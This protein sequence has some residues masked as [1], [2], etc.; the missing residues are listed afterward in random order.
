MWLVARCLFMY[1]D[2]MRCHLRCDV[3]S[4]LLMWRDVTGCDVMR[5]DVMRCDVMCCSET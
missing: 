4:C 3:V 2:V 5:C 1:S